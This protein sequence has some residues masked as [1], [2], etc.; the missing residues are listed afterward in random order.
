MPNLADGFLWYL[1]FLFSTVFHEAA[2]ALLAYK[3]GDP[4]AYEGGQ[5][6]LNPAPHIRREPFGTV[7]VPLISFLMGGWMIGWASTPYDPSWAQR[8]PKRSA[9]MALAGPSSNLL[10]AVA[11]GLLIRLGMTGGVFYPPNTITLSQVTA[12]APGGLFSAAAALVSIFFTLNILLFLFNLLPFPPLDG[13]GIVPLFLTERATVKYMDFMHNP[14]FGLIGLIL[15]WNA[16]DYIFGP[17]HLLA[18]Q[19]LYPGLEY[20]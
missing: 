13:S 11:A 3:L 15:A 1:A 9:F 7:A 19:L 12:A 14:A 10:L 20:R 6:T 2:H 8:F 4:T 5:V 17:V 18:I 16:F